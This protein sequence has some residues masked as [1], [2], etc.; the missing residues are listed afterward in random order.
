[1]IPTGFNVVVICLVLSFAFTVLY[2]GPS[3]S[4]TVLE[5]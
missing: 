2:G 3:G 1:M 5:L 4:C